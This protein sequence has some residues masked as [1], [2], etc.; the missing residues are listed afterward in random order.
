M[1]DD[2]EERGFYGQGTATTQ[3]GHFAIGAVLLG[4]TAC[5]P[6]PGDGTDLSVRFHLTPQE[7]RVGD[8]ITVHGSVANVGSTTNEIR[9]RVAGT[10]GVQVEL[11]S[12]QIGSCIQAG[13]VLDCVVRPGDPLGPGESVPFSLDVTASAPGE[14]MFAA[15][16]TSDG[17]EEAPDP[18]TN[19][20]LRT[21]QVEAA[22]PSAVTVSGSSWTDSGPVF[23]RP[24]TGVPFLLKSSLEVEGGVVDGLVATQVLPPGLVADSTLGIFEGYDP[25]VNDIVQVPADCEVFEGVVSCAFSGPIS[26]TWSPDRFW[27]STWVHT[28]VAGLYDVGLDLVGSDPLGGG[29][30]R[31]TGS[32]TIEV[33]EMPEPAAVEGQ[34][35]YETT[36]EFEQPTEGAWFYAVSTMAVT[37]GTVDDLV[38]T[39][40]AARR[41]RGGRHRGGRLRGVGSRERSGRLRRGRV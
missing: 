35:S 38:V 11:A 22:A 27:V 39:Q 26:S 28:E 17:E 15:L 14:A 37:S 30:A 33:V 16:A 31:F 21:V 20:D 3:R 19:F 10:S 32:D 9:F 6:I 25:A 2:V 4:L 12:G 24:V 7:L 40:I 1:F 41:R 5:D 18:T 29:P 34:T 8:E 36:G 13:D 23:P